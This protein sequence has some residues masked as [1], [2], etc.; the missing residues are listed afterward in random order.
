MLI[1]YGSV[2][3]LIAIVAVLAIAAMIALVTRA[4]SPVEPMRPVTLSDEDRML[5]QQVTL[6]LRRKERQERKQQRLERRGADDKRAG[7]KPDGESF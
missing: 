3:W 1:A 4:A 5:L 6:D 7:G 2:A